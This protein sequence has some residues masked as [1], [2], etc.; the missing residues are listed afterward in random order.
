[1]ALA[2]GLN[3]KENNM[4]NIRWF[5]TKEEAKAFAKTKKNATIEKSTKKQVEEFGKEYSYSVYWRI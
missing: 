1:M 2:K 5:E 3:P 4:T